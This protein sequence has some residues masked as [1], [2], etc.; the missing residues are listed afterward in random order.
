MI[1]LARENG[2]MLEEG[3]LPVAGIGGWQ[4]CFITSTSRHVMPVTSIDGR[5]VGSGEVGPVTQRLHDL[6]EGYF[7]SQ[8]G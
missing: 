8:V 4:E 7:K 5:P 3:E 6:F 1:R 2:V